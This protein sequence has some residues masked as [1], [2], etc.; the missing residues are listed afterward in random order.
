MR[1][2]VNSSF[3]YETA[4]FLE[5]FR[6]NWTWKNVKIYG[7]HIWIGADFFK[8]LNAEVATMQKL[9]NWFEEQIN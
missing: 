1:K 4:V 8:S 6:H 7:V 3:S 5:N 9:V 2:T